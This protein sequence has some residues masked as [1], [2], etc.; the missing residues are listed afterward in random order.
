MKNYFT[1]YFNPLYM[2]GGVRKLYKA[3][4]S[5]G[6]DTTVKEL[7]DE[8]D[9]ENKAL[10]DDTDEV[11]ALKKISRQVKNFNA[12]LGTKAKAEDFTSVNTQLAAL[13]KDI[14]T[15]KADD[16]SKALVDINEANTKI[17]KQIAELQEENL[18]AK[19]TGEGTSKRKP[20]FTKKEVEDFVAATFKDGSKTHDN[21]AIKMEVFKAAETFGIPHTFD[22]G[23]E[24]TDISAFTGRI[25]DPTLYQ[26]KRKRNLILDNFTIGSISVPKL[27]YLIKVED[28][29]DSG[30]A[31][32]DSGGAGWI[33]S[34]EIKPKRSFRVTTG[35][36]EAKKVAIFGTIED[37]LLKDVPSF[38]RWIREDFMDEMKEEINDGLL[39]NNP[40]VDPKAPLG[41]KTN[42]V[43]F[44]ATAAFL[45][46]YVATQ[47]TYIDQII[48]GIAFMADNK[49]DAA[50]VFVSNDVYYAILGLKDADRRYQ[51]NNLVYTN[52]L[53]Q[54]YIVGVPIIRADSD[55]IPATHVLITAADLGFKMYAYGAM[56]FERGLN[57]EDFR[58]DRTSYRGYQE[59]LSF[60]PE[61]RENSVMYDTWANLQA[62]I[63]A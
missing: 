33:L 58:Y 14:A 2:G 18:K 40:A 21:A 37:K 44:T 3:T 6:G 20:L 13:Q 15:M 38:E 25:V 47:S 61:N 49:E 35:E 27:I 29:D 50:Q 34:G 8:T 53:G 5:E 4:E 11:K 32:G 56:V 36:A 28:G 39:N 19:E 54:L 57:G 26:R 63:E 10:P 41:L 7:T 60:L 46:K 43:Q 52:S 23:A 12:I 22:S 48:A 9:P 17:W 62:G 30:S 51:N 45:N 55:D 1:R 59:F 31:P 24:P 16:I 42:A